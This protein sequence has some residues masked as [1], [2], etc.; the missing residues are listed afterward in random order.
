M[1]PAS[2]AAVVAVIASIAS[3][4]S[5]AAITGQVV[6]SEISNADLNNAAAALRQLSKQVSTANLS[7]NQAISRINDILN[8]YQIVKST[9]AP[10]IQSIINSRSNKLE[11][12]KND[13][14]KRVARNEARLTE[15][16]SYYTQ[17]A[18]RTG[19]V[20]GVQT[21]SDNIGGK[22]NELSRQVETPI[23][24]N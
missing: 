20:G 4:L 9:L 13:L 7:Y 22:I 23:S 8:N 16:Q 6:G 11:V 18:G 2:I 15:G 14:A 3:T 24:E 17:A 12:K 1:D 10:R 21:M 5:Q 19:M